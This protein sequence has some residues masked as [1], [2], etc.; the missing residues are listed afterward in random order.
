MNPQHEKDTSPIIVALSFSFNEKTRGKSLALRKGIDSLLPFQKL[1]LAKVLSVKGKWIAGEGKGSWIWSDR[2]P[3]IFNHHTVKTESTQNEKKPG[4]QSKGSVNRSIPIANTIPT[5][6]AMS[7]FFP[8][9]IYLSALKNPKWNKAIFPLN[10]LLNPKM[11]QEN[12]I[13]HTTSNR[14]GE[15]K[16]IYRT[17]L[18]NKALNANQ[19]LDRGVTGQNKKEHAKPNRVLENFPQKNIQNTHISSSLGEAQFSEKNESISS[20]RLPNM[21]IVKILE[22]AVAT[23][24]FDVKK[25]SI[26]DNSTNVSFRGYRAPAGNRKKLIGLQSDTHA[27]D[28]VLNGAYRRRDAH[29][30]EIEGLDNAQKYLKSVTRK[31]RSPLSILQRNQLLNTRPQ[32]RREGKPTTDNPQA[33]I[34]DAENGVFGP[35]NMEQTFAWKKTAAVRNRAI[36]ENSVLTLKPLITDYVTNHL[37]KV[38]E[39]KVKKQVHEVTREQVEKFQKDVKNAA[40]VIKPEHVATDEA[41]YLLMK[42]IQKIMQQDRF[43][44]GQLG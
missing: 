21:S 22:S 1:R 4:A 44:R 18:L 3:W 15:T 7:H 37:E 20:I 24:S 31:P 23:A 40:T 38:I 13:K 5:I 8:K 29:H 42:K 35:K 41:A 14:V 17:Q 2:F 6:F 28:V 34:N 25:A 39:D 10:N 12:S 9:R 43:R 32:Y 19:S 26:P 36:R 11:T 27:N 16:I 33:L 30:V